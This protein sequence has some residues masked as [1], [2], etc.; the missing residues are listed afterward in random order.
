MRLEKH[1]TGLYAFHE[2]RDTRHE[3][4]N[5]NHGLLSGCHG[6]SRV[7]PPE[8]VAVPPRTPA[9]HGFYAR[10]FP[11]FPTI[12]RQEI[13]PLSQR[14]RIVS[15]SRWASRRALLAGKSRKNT[16]NPACHRKMREAQ[17]LP[18]LS[19]PSG[20]LAL[21]LPRNEPVLRKGTSCFMLIMFSAGSRKPCVTVTGMGSPRASRRSCQEL[22]CRS[23]RPF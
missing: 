7:A 4:R 10:H 13:L 17:R 1:E 20:P 18:R 6:C 12:S 11:L 19:S 21:R 5:T 14:Q 3:T 9:S 22:S 15:R 16:Q 23:L 8:T 2:S